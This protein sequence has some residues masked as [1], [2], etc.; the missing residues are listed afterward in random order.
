MRHTF[1]LFTSLIFVIS[2]NRQDPATLSSSKD[3]IDSLKTELN[4][5]DS[6]LSEMI[7]EKSVLVEGVKSVTHLSAGELYEPIVT[8]SITDYN[9][10]EILGYIDTIYKYYS[11]IH[12][13]NVAIYSCGNGP[14]DPDKDY[15]NGSYNLYISTVQADLPPTIFLHE[16]GPFVDLEIDSI[17]AQNS[18]III[19]HDLKG[20]R[21][22]EKFDIKLGKI[23]IK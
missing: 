16:T 21:K 6:L 18:N 5:R 9:L 4:Y 2:C 23:K 3:L 17:D 20:S 8:R 14:S 1:K 19:S 13:V 7:H 12:D 15:C 11:R 10:N 22:T